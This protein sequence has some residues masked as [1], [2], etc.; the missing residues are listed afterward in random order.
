MNNQQ[1]LDAKQQ[2][3]ND[4]KG[5]SANNAIKFGQKLF[6]EFYNRGWFTIERFGACGTTL[7]AS[8]FPAY[9]KTHLALVSWDVPD[10]E[11]RV[12]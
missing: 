12:R 9:D 11:Y 4:L 8:D 3:D 6:L 1:V 2:L 10:N 5:L 7:F